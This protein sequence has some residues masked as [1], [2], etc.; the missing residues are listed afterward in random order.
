MG[1][2]YVQNTTLAYHSHAMTFVVVVVDRVSCTLDL[3]SGKMV[4]SSDA[5]QEGGPLSQSRH[6]S[7]MEQPV[8]L[9]AHSGAKLFPTIII[10][11]TTENVVDF[12][13][14]P[15]PGCKCLSSSFIP[16]PPQPVERRAKR[17]EVPSI[18]LCPPR[19]K[20]MIYSKSLWVRQSPDPPKYSTDTSGPLKIFSKELD[21]DILVTLPQEDK[22]MNILEISED[23]ELMHFLIRTLEAFCAVC[24][25]SNLVLA[26]SIVQFINSNQI[27]GCLHVS[28]EGEGR[29]VCM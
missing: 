10:T 7:P 17:N 12:D 24:S 28:H 27:L 3:L 1:H 4:F 25:H 16:P 18:P 2:S 11:P 21:Y 23:L 8:T 26:K 19:L 6:S 5:Q 9:T 14:T 22:V 29:G 20:L 15:S 13:F